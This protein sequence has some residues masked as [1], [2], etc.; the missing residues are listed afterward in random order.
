MID[1][2]FERLLQ[3]NRIVVINMYI[4]KLDVSYN[5]LP[6][7]HPSPSAMGKRKRKTNKRASNLEGKN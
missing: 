6:I 3:V 5:F 1:L 2:I 7:R 4:G